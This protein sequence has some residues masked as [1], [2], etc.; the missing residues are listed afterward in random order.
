[1]FFVLCFGC[2]GGVVL[3]S[4]L[5]GGLEKVRGLFDGS[6]VGFQVSNGCCRVGAPLL[7][8]FLWAFYEVL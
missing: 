5:R 2:F 1:M 7:P 4:R 6:M 3:E 8:G